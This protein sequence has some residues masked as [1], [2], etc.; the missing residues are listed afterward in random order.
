VFEP[1]IRPLSFPEEGIRRDDLLFRLPNVDDVEAVMPAFADESIGGAANLPPLDA[2]QVRAQAKEFPAILEHG[3]LLPLIVAD[4]ETGEVFGG[5]VL[6]DL[7]WKLG[8]AEIGYWLFPHAQGRGIATR[9][10]RFLADHGFSLGLERIEARVFVGNDASERVLERAGFRR[11]GLLRSLPRTW[12]GRADM[13]VW[14][15]LPGE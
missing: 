12:G 5:G 9:T 7:N 4:A 14:S 8:Q 11:E 3:L 13:S 15:L 6:H 2:E 10:A 1:E